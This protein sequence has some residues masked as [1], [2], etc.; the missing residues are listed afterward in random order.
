VT[1][2]SIVQQV[3]AWQSLPIP[4]AVFSATDPQTVELRG[5]L[6]E[7]IGELKK[8]PDCYWR[9]LMRQQTFIS[10]A[11]DV[12]TLDPAARRPRVHHSQHHVGPDH[13]AALPGADRSG[14]RGRHGRRG[15]S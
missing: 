1:A 5:L 3:C 12:Q 2:L 6:N 14:R 9:K 10:E 8:W 7:E 13:D 4:Q 15:R 11:S